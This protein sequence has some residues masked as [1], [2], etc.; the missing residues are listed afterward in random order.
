MVEDFLTPDDIER[1]YYS[2]R[3]DIYGVA[4]ARF[5]NNALQAPKRSPRYRGL[6]FTGGSINPGGG[7]CR[8]V[9]CGQKVRDLILRDLAS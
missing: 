6:H 5:R 2:T 3:G 7:T 8:V 1:I 9:L 4:A